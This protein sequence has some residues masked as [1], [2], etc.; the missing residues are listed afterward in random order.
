M[1]SRA[2]LIAQVS[3]GMKLI[4]F[5][6]HPVKLTNCILNRK[7]WQITVGRLPGNI[8]FFQFISKTAFVVR[9]HKIM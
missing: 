1:I 9:M 8:I 2:S 3:I 4:N 7:W 5:N 6:G